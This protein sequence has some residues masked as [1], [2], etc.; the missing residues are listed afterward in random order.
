[1]RLIINIIICFSLA[2][3]L[4]CC[5]NEGPTYENK[6]AVN[7]KSQLKEKLPE[8]GHRNWILIVDKAFPAQNADGIM[9]INTGEDLLD[10]LDYTLLEIERSAHVSPIVYTDKELSFITPDLFKNIEDYRS[11]LEKAVGK[12]NTQV[13]LH[14]S[15]FV[16]IDEA[17]KLFNVLV[18][19]T[20]ETIPYSSVFIELDC[21]YWSGEKENLLRNI[22]AH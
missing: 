16:K 12:Y 22:M 21:K 2:T 15:V 19:K 8:F 13:L 11:E 3:T 9:I 18:L 6:S 7:W 5:I 1:M 10:V 4:S 14:D 17:S 20:N